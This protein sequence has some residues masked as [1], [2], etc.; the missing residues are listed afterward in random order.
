MTTMTPAETD[1]AGGP[2]VICIGETM[3]MLAP[4]PH[5]LVEY[6]DHFVALNGGA[7]SNV[8]IGL[9]RLGIHAGWIGKLP[10][11]ALGRK[12][13]NEIRSFGVDVS[14][15]V[16]TERGRVGTFFVEWGAPP[17]PLA[18]IYDRTGSA[19]TT[20]AAEDL[21]WNHVR[22]AR[23]LVLTG[24]TP[25]L[26]PICRRS[27]PAIARRAR[28]LGVKVAFDINYRSLLWTADELR[29]SCREI[30]PH[31]SL[32]V[33]TESDMGMLVEG[34]SSREK[35]LQTLMGEYDLEAAVMTLGGEGCLAYDGSAFHRA[36][37]HPAQIV[38]RLGAGDAFVAG[39][40]YGYLLHDL[41]TAL[42]YGMAMAVLKLTIPQ[43]IPLVVRED[44]ERLVNG[45]RSDLVR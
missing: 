2:Q 27:T 17:R 13:V 32:L 1:G 10:R 18:T 4:P 43:N 33:G 35:V 16:W 5:E 19:A 24:I 36:P 42:V 38:N 26:S 37:A 20:L 25:A 34:S 14:S 30:L 40:L 31:V 45:D 29:E 44:V 11:N 12:I 23:W 9:E 41:P 7:E 15:V 3:L 6:C 8:A 21:D 28:Q 39:L 22:R